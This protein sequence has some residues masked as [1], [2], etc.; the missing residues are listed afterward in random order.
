MFLAA[1]SQLGVAPPACLALAFPPGAVMVTS[2]L[3]VSSWM[4]LG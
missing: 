2:L 1:P 4:T 3:E